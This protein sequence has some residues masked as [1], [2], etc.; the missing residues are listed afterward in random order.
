M[1]IF[2]ESYKRNNLKTTNVTMSTTPD[3][4]K[5]YAWD[6]DTEEIL[7]D[8]NGKLTIVE[9]LEA[10]KVRVWLALQIQRNRYLIYYS[11][12]GNRLKSLIGKNSAYINKNIQSLLD[13]ALVDNIYITSISDITCTLDD[14]IV[15][16]E[17]TVNSI[18][19]SYTTTTTT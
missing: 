10:V 13:E 9:G 12:I 17:F 7:I 11:G 6:F 5:E 14:D 8:E 18:Y 1:S 19:G 3:L 4:L 15:T 2:P 16:I